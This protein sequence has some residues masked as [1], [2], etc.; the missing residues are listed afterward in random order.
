ML[1]IF[2]PGDF[3]KVNLIGNY[4]VG[5]TKLFL[6]NKNGKGNA[7]SVFYPVD[8]EFEAEVL[9]NKNEATYKKAFDYDDVERFFQTC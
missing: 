2:G 1:A 9:K 4:A 3:S 5:Y 8:K 7:V 6:K